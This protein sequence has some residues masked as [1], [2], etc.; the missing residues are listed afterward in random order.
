MG[1]KISVVFVVLLFVF[2]L[3]I[4]LHVWSSYLI[5]QTATTVMVETH[6]AAH[7]NRSSRRLFP[8]NN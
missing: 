8:W 4:G 2:A 6:H 1:M 7:R 5:V 3:H